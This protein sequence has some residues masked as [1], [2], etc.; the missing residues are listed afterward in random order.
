M[1]ILVTGANGQLGTSLKNISASVH[2]TFFF[3][4]TD[5]DIC[6][7]DM[8]RYF[9]LDKQI[10]VIINC[11]AYTAVN[12]A[13]SDIEKAT[14][15]NHIGTKNLAEIAASED[16]RII[17]ISTDYVFDGLS[18]RPYIETDAVNPL[19]VYGKT[20]LA[21]EEE[22]I[23]CDA[24][25][26]IR[27]SWLY[28]EY[29]NNFLHT[30]YRLSTEKDELRV[31]FD[32]IGTP[33]YA[34]DVAKAILQIISQDSKLATAIYHYSNEG[35]ASWYDFAWEIVLLS[36]RRC[37]IIPIESK[38]YPLPAPRPLYSVLNKRKIKNNFHIDIPYWKESLSKCILNI[39]K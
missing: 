18:H 37:K 27:T 7:Y 35:V 29:S 16:C 14:Q 13:E 36:G 30:I 12:K 31:V 19:S 8:I 34:G 15:I 26:I 11:A 5:L 28:S 1:N 25:M 38:D 4:D 10:D 17:H 9:I 39:K 3:H 22:V 21:G 2:H 6:N 33:T 24:G 23:R 32:Q 20:K